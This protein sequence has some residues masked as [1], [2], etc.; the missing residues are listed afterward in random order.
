MGPAVPF[1]NLLHVICI[2]VYCIKYFCRQNKLAGKKIKKDCVSQRVSSRF[3]SLSFAEV[4]CSFLWDVPFKQVHLFQ[5]EKKD[6]LEI[7]CCL[8]SHANSS[9]QFSGGPSQELS[10]LTASVL[11][12]SSS[13]Y[14]AQSVTLPTGVS[15][16]LMAFH[17][18]Q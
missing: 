9:C 7:V 3:I 6:H 1:I 13:D 14:A 18:R 8:L 17:T 12:P 2:L 4:L 15:T 11:S 16:L 5:G 10:P